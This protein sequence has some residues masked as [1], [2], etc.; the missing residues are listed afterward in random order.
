MKKPIQIQIPLDYLPINPFTKSKT[1]DQFL[2]RQTNLSCI[3][4]N[5]LGRASIGVTVSDYVEVS[6]HMPFVKKILAV[7]NLPSTDTQK[8]F[9]F[10]F[11]RLKPIALVDS[12]M[13]TV[14]PYQR[15]T[16]DTEKRLQS[17]FLILE[18]AH[19]NTLL[20]VLLPPESVINKTLRVGLM[21]D[22]Y[23]LRY[24]VLNGFANPGLVS[25][26]HRSQSGFAIKRT[27]YQV[28]L[29]T[30]KQDTVHCIIGPTYADKIPVLQSL[31]ELSKERITHA[32]QATLNRKFSVLDKD[33]YVQPDVVKRQAELV[34]D[35]RKIVFGGS[36][37]IA[38]I[39][40]PKTY[41]KRWHEYVA[42][43]IQFVSLYSHTIVKL[44]YD[45]L[46]KQIILTV[47]S[48]EP[49]VVKL[50]LFS[51]I[52]NSDYTLWSELEYKFVEYRTN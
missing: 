24:I 46:H 13:A 45:L 44:D 18:D 51:R 49:D 43:P 26:F 32:I 33:V 3:L 38:D 31:S 25:Y 14:I 35:P 20:N 19:Q 8:T 27:L 41:F 12:T 5:I 1:I 11:R 47:K 9:V 39:L 50:W 16:K 10:R 30:P 15:L 52:Q 28:S 4:S 48:V 37:W 40:G 42:E 22:K 21:F 34:A 17:Y 7:L 2:E 23:V 36:S 6:K 29:T